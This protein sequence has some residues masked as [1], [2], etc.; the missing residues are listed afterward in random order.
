MPIGVPI[1]IWIL[2]LLYAFF[3]SGLD[4]VNH[5][6]AST[7]QCLLGNKPLCSADGAGSQGA[8]SAY[9]NL[10]NALG[11]EAIVEYVKKQIGLPYVN[12]GPTNGSVA[13]PN[14]FDCSG[15]SRCAALYASKGK[16]N[17]VHHAATQM[18]QLR[19]YSVAKTPSA[20][21]PGDFIYYFIP[22]DSSTPGHVT[23]YV[24][25]GQ[26]VGA[27]RPGENVKQEPWSQ[28]PGTYVMGV[29]RPAAA[30]AN[31]RPGASVHLAAVA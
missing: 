15:L 3:E 26:V 20:W 1:L 13:H 16:L 10:G 25:E 19:A 22:G 12:A 18:A 28:G 11:G 30:I 27:P 7:V 31:T 2:T 21:E 4:L 17:L 14:N 29:R 6:K 24:G 8:D 9:T 23:I 5:C